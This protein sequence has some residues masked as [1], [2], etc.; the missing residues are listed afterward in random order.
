MTMVQ[1]AFEDIYL[2]VLDVDGIDCAHSL[3]YTMDEHVNQPLSRE[4]SW[5]FRSSPVD[6]RLDDDFEEN[7]K[8]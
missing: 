7:E 5:L 2:L 3:F 4:P 1:Q 8:K 6:F